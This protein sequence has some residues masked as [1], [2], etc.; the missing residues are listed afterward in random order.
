MLI[1]GVVVADLVALHA[2]AS[3]VLKLAQVVDLLPRRQHALTQTAHEVLPS[4]FSLGC[5]QAAETARRRKATPTVRYRC[6]QGLWANN[7]VGCRN[8]N[9]FKPPP[10]QFGVRANLVWHPESNKADPNRDRGE[11]EIY[12]CFKTTW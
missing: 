3:Q 4:F 8:G 1:V 5:V 11:Y 6:A 12:G 9:F 7:N 10:A 2:K